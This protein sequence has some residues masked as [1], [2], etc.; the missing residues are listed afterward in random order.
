MRLRE[1]WSKHPNFHFVPHSTS[2]LAKLQD[3]LEQ[4]QIIVDDNGLLHPG[5]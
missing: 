2:F 1:L 3:G 4:L 5:P